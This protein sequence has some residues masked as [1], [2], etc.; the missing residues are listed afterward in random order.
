LKIFLLWRVKASSDPS[1]AARVGAELSR[2]FAPLLEP[3]AALATR[4]EGPT[5]LAWLEL[6]VKGF[7]VPFFEEDGKSW[8]FAPD[9]PLNARRLLRAHGVFPKDGG[10]VL[11][12]LARELEARREPYVRELIPP[13]ALIWGRDGEVRVQS[14]GLGQA[15][16][17]E[18]EDDDTWALTNRPCALRALGVSL[19]PVALDW[20]ARFTT[21]WFPRHASGLAGVR[22]LPGGTLLRLSGRGVERSRFDPLGDWVNPPPRSRADG[23]EAGRQALLDHVS[24]AMELWVKPTVGLSGGWDSRCVASCLRVLGADFEL[25]VR[26]QETHFDV[27]ISAALARMAGLPHRIKSEGGVPPNSVPG[28]RAS[29]AKALLW[30]AGNYTTLKHKSFLAKEGK[31]RL[32]G[33]VVNVMG[34]HAGIGKAD[35]AKRIQAEAHPPARYEE[36]LLASLMAEAPPILRPDLLEAVRAELRRSY[37]VA[38]DYGLSRRGPL[39]FFFLN[40]YTRRW[41]AA[42]VSGQTGFVVT[43]FLNPGFIRACYGLPEEEL[44]TKPL[45]R[46]VTGLHAPEWAAFPYTDQATE[47]DLRSG[48]IPP[49]EVPRE[50]GETVEAVVPR[51]RQTGRHRKFHYKYYWKDVG[52]PLLD[53]AFEQGGFWTE[54][55]DPPRARAQWNAFKSGADV[56]AIAHLLPQVLAGS[57]PEPG[58]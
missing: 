48:L 52:K 4:S 45:H 10:S 2:L 22:L 41:G 44:V 31:E 11:L 7:R 5:H 23:L 47:D 50:E 18:H 30:Q 27:L 32:D 20:A 40:E 34:Q 37:R 15:P 9:Y 57:M 53:E 49:V 16:L 58:S 56:I 8:A 26:G 13:A 3:G 17:Y 33:G 55:F 46:Y 25:R 51:W 28:L 35:F 12:A 38:L 54:L 6:P 42:T 36:L 19:K 39:H 29:L 43:P 24:D 14:D 21:H 1:G